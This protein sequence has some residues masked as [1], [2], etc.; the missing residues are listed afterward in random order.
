MANH[1]GKI[2]IPANTKPWPHEIKAAEALAS[3]GFIVEFIPK[4]NNKSPDVLLNNHAFE[5]KSPLSSN[6]NRIIKNIRQAIPQSENI[7][8]DSLRIKNWPSKK[9]EQLLRNQILT[10]P[11]IKRL[12]FITKERQ[13]IDIMGNTL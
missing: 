9:I 4:T 13:V 3:S 8:L 11:K 2:I 7:V 1:V 6:A 10:L 12:L 5:L